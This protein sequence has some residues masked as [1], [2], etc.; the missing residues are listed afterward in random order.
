MGN[1]AYTLSAWTLHS[2]KLISAYRDDSRRL[3]GSSH[4]QPESRRNQLELTPLLRLGYGW[5]QDGAQ[6][7]DKTNRILRTAN[8]GLGRSL[9]EARG[10]FHNRLV[11]RDLPLFRDPREPG[12]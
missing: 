9:S 7:N 12:T 8:S 5:E 6:W 4:P 2:P 3:T 1:T 10:P 11:S